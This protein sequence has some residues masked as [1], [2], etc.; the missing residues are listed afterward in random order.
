LYVDDMAE[1]SV[2]VMNL[3]HDE[4]LAQVHHQ[5]SHINVGF[6][7]DIPIAVLAAI[8]SRAVG[9]QGATSFDA[10]KPDGAPRK[11]MASRRLVS[12]GWNPKVSLEKGL[13]IAHADLQK[14]Y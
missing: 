13:A 5:L 8:I 14:K 3:E 10:S 2:F 4:Y 12:M 9:Y 6:G 7:S 1:A 11:L